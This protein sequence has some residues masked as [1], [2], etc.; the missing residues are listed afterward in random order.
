ML[1]KDPSK[2]PKLK[3]MKVKSTT[4]LNRPPPWWVKI[5]ELIKK[6]ISKNTDNF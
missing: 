2:P 1:K 4:D 3:P 6:S 5:K